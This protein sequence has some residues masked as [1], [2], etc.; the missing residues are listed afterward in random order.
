MQTVARKASALAARMNCRTSTDVVPPGH[1]LSG[2][3]GTFASMAGASSSTGFRG[4]ASSVPV[5]AC[6]AEESDEDEE[7]DEES[8]EEG[9]NTYRVVLSQQSGAPP[10]TQPTQE[11]CG[12]S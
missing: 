10:V 1:S 7:E 2:C 8:E 6:A 12:V 5:T 9:E 4:G 11:V 3:T